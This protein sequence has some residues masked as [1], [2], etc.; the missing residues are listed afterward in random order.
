MPILFYTKT[1]EY[2]DFSNFSNHGI[3]MEG[4]WYR[5]VEH[6]FQTQKFDDVEH[7]SAIRNAAS[8]K[9]AA[10]LGRSRAIP[11]RPDWEDIKIQVMRDAVLKKFQ[12]HNAARE[13][14]LSTDS[15]PLI[16]NAPGD[17]FWGC[18]KDGTGLNWLGR[19][20]EEVREKLRGDVPT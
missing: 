14:L 19:I 20:L 2:G 16:E 9:A 11:I 8:A 13:L 12:T 3:E 7:R 5:T 6:Y 4:E 10:E 1:D 15:E 18:G 17:F